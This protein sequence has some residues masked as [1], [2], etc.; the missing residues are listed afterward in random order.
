MKVANNQNIFHFICMSD[1]FENEIF[2]SRVNPGGTS[3]SEISSTMQY[4]AVLLYFPHVT[5]SQSN[6]NN[7]RG[8]KGYSSIKICGGTW[9]TVK[10]VVGECHSTRPHCVADVIVPII[11]TTNAGYH[12]IDI[13]AIRRNGHFVFISGFHCIKGSGLYFNYTHYYHSRYRVG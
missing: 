5:T 10:I 13:V 8:W 3:M 12:Q 9:S 1:T 7:P 2:D 4:D 11:V 6:T